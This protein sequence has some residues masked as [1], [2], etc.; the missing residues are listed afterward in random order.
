MTLVRPFDDYEIMAGQGTL[1]IELAEQATEAGDGRA[2]G[3]GRVDQ[4]LVPVGGGGL[5]AGVSTAVRA[6]LPGTSVIGV[7]PEGADDTSRS[8]RAGHRVRLER[9]DTIADGLRASQPGEL[10]FA[11]NS[12]TLDDVVTVSEDAI[13]EAMRFCFTRMKVVV[14]PSGAVALAALR[15]GAV[16]AA[17]R[18]S[19]AVVSGGNVDPVDFAALV[20]ASQAAVA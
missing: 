1:G 4:V 15:S 9:V 10:T 5:A 16:P 8:V 20:G 7:E 13:A 19:V 12:R 3:N 18:R 6:L 11:V 2:A 17:G 14:E